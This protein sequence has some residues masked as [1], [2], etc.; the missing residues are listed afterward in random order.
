MVKPISLSVRDF[1]LACPLKGSIETQS[2]YGALPVTGQEVHSRYL[3]LRKKRIPDYQIEVKLEGS[4]SSG[5]KQITLKGRLDGLFGQD[6][7]AIEEVKSDFDIR[8]LQSRLLADCEHPYILQVQTYGYIWYLENGVIPDMSLHLVSTRDFESIVVPVQLHLERFE[9][10]LGRRLSAVVVEYQLYL[11]E[12]KRR[13]Q[14]AARLTFPFSSMRAGQKEFV[15]SVE[16]VVGAGSQALFQA[17]TGLG[18]TMAVLYPT[19]KKAL[20]RGSQ[21]IYVT[22]KNSQHQVA[23]QS[24]ERLQVQDP[25]LKALTLTAKSKMCLK[26]EVFCNPD[27]CQYARDYYGKVVEHQIVDKVAQANNL[28]H[29]RFDEYGRKY[30]V[31][32]FELSLDTINRADVVIGDYNY[33]FS[34]RNIMGRFV[35][36]LGF[37][38]ELPDLVVDEAHNLPDRI[39]SYYSA[40]L[41]IDELSDLLPAMQ[42]IAP[43]FSISGRA[44]VQDAIEL[45]RS[46]NNHK[47]HE[48]D[49]KADDFDKLLERSNLLCRDY[50]AGSLFVG[51]NDVMLSLLR[52]LQQFSDALA[53]EKGEYAT[54][55]KK[56]RGG[57]VKVICL[58]ATGRLKESYRNLRS[59]V[60]FSAT[61]KPFD[62]FARL[63]A[64]EEEK[65]VVEEFQS[66]FPA[67]NRKL[68]IIPQVS[69]RYVDREKN[70]AK[71]ASA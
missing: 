68:L 3:N 39:K 20:S 36:R 42:K 38:K 19:I 21:V 13:E 52:Q 22:P 23:K 29:K 4:F 35:P 56:S 61:L 17:P 60:A 7:I 51:R 25:T 44:L 14:I 34:P 67:Y 66:P 1:A 10:W 69:T 65:L 28:D 18:K 30:E 71:I 32:P 24:V 54:I 33:V 59:T 9:S 64:M 49:L 46:R 41:S 5:D 40:Q 62:Y 15:E 8:S 27:Y 50:L 53:R 31:C 47:D 48:I 6:P 12:K 70:Y 55:W 16:R 11:D 2:G 45:I 43:N 63:L 37:S 26:E 58:D 57:L